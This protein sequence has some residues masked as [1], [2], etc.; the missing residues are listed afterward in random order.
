MRAPTQLQ[1][2]RPARAALLARLRPALLASAIVACGGSPTAAEAPEAPTG[3]SGP[4]LITEFVGF[5]D[6]ARGMLVL[7]PQ[8][9][10]QRSAGVIAQG[11]A[12]V[13][14]VQDGVPS[15]G[16]D[17]S[18]ELVTEST[19]IKTGAQGC[20]AFDAFSGMVTLRSFFPNSTLQN[21]Y[22]ELTRVTP[23]GHEACNSS[24]VP[25]GL[26]VSDALGLFAYGTIAAKG[27]ASDHAT[28]EWK[29]LL[30]TT[31]NFGFIGRVM[32]DVVSTV[33]VPTAFGRGA[34]A[35]G[36]GSVPT[37]N[38][39]ASPLITTRSTPGNPPNNY[40]DYLRFDLS[41]AAAEIDLASAS[42]ATLSF[43]V[44]G[45]NGTVTFDFYGLP[46]GLPGDAASGWAELGLTFGNGPGNAGKGG[47]DLSFFTTAPGDSNGNFLSSLG[48]QSVLNP[49][50]NATVSFSS[51]ALL[52]W[53][54]SDTNG[55]VTIALRRG[56]A[57]GII[58]LH[59]KEN[60]LGL[61]APTLTVVGP[62]R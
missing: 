6:A 30:P 26:E 16:P 15:A 36:Q 41:A 17:N 61:A 20:G 39:G 27:G 48:Q 59:S 5:V 21:T 38:F 9:A 22:I 52:N 3:T 44:T 29:L 47:A 13:N 33:A 19:A 57:A 35:Y 7:R 34:D 11:L 56:D 43:A 24:P 60:T 58:H 31:T 10:A 46:D 14:V 37:T 1:A 8:A 12:E 51:A 54:K 28:R 2:P 42:A 40:K 4:R 32:A 50:A 25:P 23:I 18:V 49:A 53:I 45:R 62:R 55:L